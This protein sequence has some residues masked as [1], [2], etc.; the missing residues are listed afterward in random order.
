[1]D[2]FIQEHR[3]NV[4]R[5]ERDFRQGL[6]P[7]RSLP[8]VRD[9]RVL[10]AAAVVEVERLPVRA[11]IERVIDAHGVWLRPF[12]NFIYAMPPLVTDAASTARIVEAL[13]DLAASPPGPATDDEFHE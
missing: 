9:V 6:E 3:V 4:A 13:A 11:E 8:N 1:M 10:G 12:C 7:L 2:E 5:L